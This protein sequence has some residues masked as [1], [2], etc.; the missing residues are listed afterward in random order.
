MKKRWNSKRIIAI[1]MAVAMLPLSDIANAF[2]PVVH[3]A[4]VANSETFPTTDEDMHQTTN[5][6]AAKGVTD[7]SAETAEYGIALSAELDEQGNVQLNWTLNGAA[8]EGVYT[9]YRNELA[10]ETVS[11]D[12]GQKLSYCDA[13]VIASATYSYC[14]EKNSEKSEE[15]LPEPGEAKDA[16]FW[17]NSVNVK[18]P[19]SLTIENDSV[20]IDEDMEVLELNMSGGNLTITPDHKLTVIKDTSLSDSYLYI[21]GQLCC[22]GNLDVKS[23]YLSMYSEDVGLYVGKD[24]TW[25]GGSGYFGN[26]SARFDGNCDLN[27]YLTSYEDSHIIFGG[28]SRQDI[29]IQ[30]EY[31]AIL[32]C[33]EFQNTSSEGIHL[34]NTF[35]CE[36]IIMGD[37]NVF[38]GETKVTGDISL[39][40]DTVYEGDLCLIGKLELNGHT[41]SVKGNLIQPMGQIVLGGGK[42]EV[43]GDYRMLYPSE[44]GQEDTVSYGYIEME[45]EQDE[46]IICGDLIVNRIDPIYLEQGRTEIKGDIILTSSEPN[47]EV[48]NF[49]HQVVLSGEGKQEIISENEAYATIAELLLTNSS[50]DGIVFHDNI[51]VTQEIEDQCGKTFGNLLLNGEVKGYFKGNV[52]VNDGLSVNDDLTIDGDLTINGGLDVGGSCVVAGNLTID[53]G[54]FGIF[55][56]GYL[57]IK[58]NFFYSSSYAY[59]S[60]DAGTIECK[61]NLIS[62]GRLTA[63]GDNRFLFS[64]NE[65]QIISTDINDR[66]AII[67]LKNTSAE[68]VQADRILVCSSLIKNDSKFE[69]TQVALERDKR[70]TEDQVYEGNLVWKEGLLDLNGRELHV[71]GNL[72][73]ESGMIDLNNGRLIIDGDYKIQKSI[74]EQGEESLTGSGLLKMDDENDYLLV[75][76]SFLVD[77]TAYGMDSSD[78]FTNGVVE[79]K[80]DVT[81]KSAGENQYFNPKGDSTLLLSGEKQQ[82]IHIEKSHYYYHSGVNHLIITNSSDAGVVL[83]DKIY[84]YGN[85]EDR[86]KHISGDLILTN[87]A[88]LTGKSFGGNLWIENYQDIRDYKI[89]GDLHLDCYSAKIYDCNVVGD[90]YSTANVNLDGTLNVD[91]NLRI[92]SGYI[93][94][95][96]GTIKVG[97]DLII[98]DNR[99]CL[100]MTHEKDCVIVAGNAELNP[101]AKYRMDE[102]DLLIAGSLSIAGDLTYGNYLKTSESHKLIL[103]GSSGQTVKPTSNQTTYLGTIIVNNQSAKGVVFDIA[104]EKYLQFKRLSNQNSKLVIAGK[105]FP[106]NITILKSSASFSHDEVIEG[107]VY[108]TGSVNVNLCKLVINGDLFMDSSIDVFGG[109]LEVKG[110]LIQSNGILEVRNS[111]NVTIDGDYRIQS[112]TVEGEKVSYSSSSGRLLMDSINETVL[113]KGNFISASTYCP[114]YYSDLS[115]GLLEVQ[116][117]FIIDDTYEK[118]TFIPYEEFT[119]K[120]SG[121]GK[122]IVDLGE[123]GTDNNYFWNLILANDSEEGIVFRQTPYV[124]GKV[125]DESKKIT[126]TIYAASINNITSESFC[127]SLRTSGR[128]EKPLSIKGDLILEETDSLVVYDKL[129]VD[130]DLFARG[131][132]SVYDNGELYVK[133]NISFQKDSSLYISTGKLVADGN[134]TMDGSGDQE[135][136]MAGYTGYMLVKGNT[137]LKLTNCYASYGTLEVLGDFT[138]IDGWKASSGE[139]KTVFSGD[140]KQKI[141]LEGDQYFANVEFKNL[142]DEGIE[143]HNVTVNRLVIQWGSKLTGEK[144]KGS[145]ETRTVLLEDRTIEGNYVLD[146]NL[147][148]NGHTLTVTGDLVHRYGDILIDGGQLVTGGDYLVKVTSDDLKFPGGTFYSLQMTGPDDKVIVNGD[149]VV[150]E[151]DKK[152]T[153]TFTNGTLEVKGDL[154]LDRSQGLL[155]WRVDYHSTLVLS[156]KNPQTVTSKVKTYLENIVINNTSEEGV[157]IQQNIILYGSFVSDQKPVRGTIGITSGNVTFDDNS[158][159]GSIDLDANVS[160]S[161]DLSIGGNLR[162]NGKALYVKECTLTVGGDLTCDSNG[163]LYIQG[164]AVVVEGNATIQG[165][166]EMAQA[167][168][169]MRVKGNMLAAPQTAVLSNGLI[170]VGGNFETKKAFHATDDHQTELDGDHKQTVTMQSGTYLRNLRLKNTSEDGIYFESLYLT[171][172]MDPGDSVYS[173]GEGAGV[174]GYT[175]TEDETYKGDL[176]LTGG[177]LDLNGH[178]LVVTGNLIQSS[179]TLRINAG[180]LRIGG[181]YKQTNESGILEMTDPSDSVIV[182]GNF[183]Y[184]YGKKIPKSLA[185][186]TLELKGNGVFGYYGENY[187]WDMSGLTLIFSGEQNQ[188]ITINKSAS[189]GN[190]INRNSAEL[191][192]SGGYEN[193]ITVSGTISDEIRSNRIFGSV[194]RVQSEDQIVDGIYGGNVGFSKSIQLTRDLKVRALTQTTSNVTVSMGDRKLEAEN[195]SV[196]TGALALQKGIITCNSFNIGYSGKLHMQDAE[197]RII[198]RGDFNSYA[199]EDGFLTAGTMEIYG[200]FVAY[201]K[202]AFVTSAEHTVVFPATSDPDAG[203]QSITV[204]DTT[205]TSK[206]TNLILERAAGDYIFSQ[207]LDAIAVNVRFEQRDVKAPESISN[208]EAVSITPTTIVIQFTESADENGIGGYRIER[209]GTIIATIKD[210]TYRD[211]GLTPDT[212]Y[213]YKVYPFDTSFNNCEESPV[214]TVKT[215]KDQSAPS[216]PRLSVKSRT[217]SSITLEWTKVFDDVKV[218]RYN[219]YR[220]EVKIAAGLTETTF[221]DTHLSLKTVYRYQVEAYDTSGNVSV[222]SSILDT[223]VMMPEFVSIEPAEESE[224]GGEKAILSV[225]FRIPSKESTTSLKIEY[226]TNTQE[227]TTLVTKF[228]TKETS[229]GNG[230]WQHVAS[231]SWNLTGLAGDQ[232]INVR[233]T[234]TD[235]DGNSVTE[236]R[237][238][239]LDR[240]APKPPTEIDAVAKD[241]TVILEWAPSVNADCA[242]YKIYRKHGETGA[243]FLIG[244]IQKASMVYYEDSDVIPG[245]Y[246]AYAIRAYDSFGNLG[247]LSEAAD[248]IVDNDTE[249]P[250]VTEI[251]PKAKRINGIVDLGIQATDNRRVK[252]ILLQYREESQQTWTELAQIN[253]QIPASYRL[254][255]TQ[256]PDG[257]Y[258]FGAVAVDSSGNKSEEKFTKRY[259]IDNTGIAKIEIKES[260]ALSTSI[261]ISWEDVEEEDFGYFLVEQLINGSYKEVARVKDRLG[262]IADGLRPLT[263]YT[264]RVAGVDTLGNKGEY[265]DPVIVSTEADTIAPVITQVLPY[266]GDVKNKLE[267]SLNAT[268]NVELGDAVISYSVDGENFVDL[269]TL[270]PSA[271]SKSNCYE[272]MFDIREMVE[273]DIYLKFE[274]YD[275]AGNHNALMQ[276]EDD[277]IFKYTIDR[278]PPSQINSITSKV[279]EGFT[280]LYW[281]I[282]EN[283]GIADFVISRA[284]AKN[285]IF[286][287]IEEH[288]TYLSYYDQN[289]QPGETYLYKIAAV[290]RAGNRGEFSPEFELKVEEDTQAPVITGILPA[291][292]TVLGL[293]AQIE[294][295][296]IDNIHTKKL[297]LEYRRIAE[298]ETEHEWKQIAQLSDQS[299]CEIYGRVTWKNGDIENG[300][301]QIRAIAEDAY[302]NISEPFVLNYRL[303]KAEPPVPELTVTGSHYRMELEYSVEDEQQ[304]E[305]YEILRRVVGATDFKSILYTDETSY[306]DTDV[307]ADKVYQYRVGAYFKNGSVSWSKVQEGVADAIDDTAPVA[308]LPENLVGL[309]GMEIAFDGMGSYDNVRVVSYEW[310][311]GDGTVLSG[312][313]PI[314]AFNAAGEY[315]VTL[316]VKDAAGNSDESSTEVTIREKSGNGSAILEV[317]GEKG[318]YIPYAYVHVKAEDGTEVNL[319]ADGFGRAVIAGAVGKCAVSAFATGYLPA[320]TEVLLFEH[321]PMNYQL[322]L[323]KEELIVG[324]LT[325][326]R[327]TIQE[328]KEAGVDL[329]DPSNYNQVQIS[330]EL[331]YR[332]CKN[333][334]PIQMIGPK[335]QTVET[336]DHTRITAQ[337][338]NYSYTPG[339][340]YITPPPVICIQTV[341]EISW[342]KDMFQ[343]ELDILNAADAEYY[344]KGT[345]A[346]LVLPEGVSLAKMNSVQQTLTQDLGTVYGQ[347]QSHAEWIVRGDTPGIKRLHADVNGILMPFE[348]PVDATFETEIQVIGG[349]GL[350]VYIYPEKHVV[351]GEDTYIQFAIVN[352]T[353]APV[354][355]FST[356]IGDYAETPTVEY[357]HDLDTGEISERE[358]SGIGVLNS[359]NMSQPVRIRDGQNLTIKTLQ[360]GG[361]VNGTLIRKVQSREAEDLQ[362][363]ELVKQAEKII[364]GE[365]T[366]IHLHTE[367][368]PGHVYIYR[369]SYEWQRIEEERIRREEEEAYRE[370]QKRIQQEEERIR[371]EEEARLQEEAEEVGDPI[372]LNTGHFTDEVSLLSVAGA[373]LLDISMRYNSG[374]S[375]FRGELGFGWHHDYEKRLELVNGTIYYHSTPFDTFTFLKDEKKQD[376]MVGRMEGSTLILAEGEEYTYGHYKPVSRAMTGTEMVRNTDG[377]YTLTYPDLRQYQFTADG[378]LSKVDDGTGITISFTYYENETVVTDDLS[379]KRLHIGYDKYHRIEKVWDD[380]G[381]ETR[382]TYE[383]D[384]LSSVTNPEGYVTKYTYDADH[385]ILTEANQQ[386]VYVDNHYD[387]HGRVTRQLNPEGEAMTLSYENDGGKTLITTTYP[388]SIVKKTL[389]NASGSIEWMLDSNGAKTEYFYDAQGNRIVEQDALGHQIAKEYD[390]RGN[391]TKIT[392]EAGNIS[393][394]EYDSHDRLLSATNADGIRS[395]FWYDDYGRPVRTADTEGNVVT[396]DYNEHGQLIKQCHEILGE[397]TFTYE[398]GL[399]KESTDYMGN[400]TQ[401]EYDGAGNLTKTTDALGNTT[402]NTYDKLGRVV[403]AT[404]ALGGKTRYTYDCNNRITS[405]TNALGDTAS[406][407]YDRVGHPVKVTYPDGSFEEQSYDACG[408]L[409]SIT[410][411]D[412]SKTVYEY[413][414]VGNRVKEIWPDGRTYTAEYDL[415]G[416]RIAEKDTK[417]NA[418]CYEY[419]PNGNLYKVKHQDGTTELYTYNKQ[420]KVAAYT[421]VTGATTSYSYDLMNRLTLERDAL[422]NETHY[423]YDELGR[424]ISQTDPN[425]NTTK[426]E[427]DANSNCTKIIDALG[428]ATYMEY[429]A[430][431]R[432]TCLYRLNKAGEKISVSYIYDAL[433]HV[434]SSTDELGQTTKMTYDAAGNLVSLVDPDGNT[435]SVSEYDSMGRAVKV[436]DEKLLETTCEYDKSGNLIE[437]V[438]FLNGEAKRSTQYE[439]DVNN[440]LV[441]VTDPMDG[442]TKMGYDERGNVASITDPN[443]GETVYTYDNMGRLLSEVDAIGSKH[444]YT[445]NAQ[446]LLTQQKNARGQETEYT[447]DKIGRVT[448]IKDDL[449]T[450]NYTYDKNGNVLTVSD[451]KGTIKRTYDALNRITSYTDYNGKT[452]KYAYDEL[453]NLVGL[454]Y[455]GGEIVRYA[456]YK[457]GMLYSVTDPEGKITTYE[458][459]SRGNLTKTVRPNGTV[460][461]CT[462]NI[463][464]LLVEQIETLNAAEEGGEATELLHY[465]YT[466]DDYGNVKA[467]DGAKTLNTPEGISRLTSVSMT[468][469]AA[470][471]LLTYNGEVVRYDADG[472]MIYGPVNGEMSSLTYDCRNRLVSAGGITYTYDPENTRISAESDTSKEVYVTENV[473]GTYSR[474]LTMTV[475]EKENGTVKGEGKETFYVYGSGLIYEK[476][477]DSILYH[478]YNN[479]GS[480]ILLTDGHGQTIAEYTYG[481]YGE[482]LSGDASLTRFLYNGRCGVSTD[483][484]G[485]YYMRQRYYN[486]EIRRFI[487]RDIVSGDITNSQSLNR[488]CYVQ[489]NPVKYTDPF[490]LSPEDG[491][492][493]GNNF[494]HGLLGLV[495]LIP[496]P[497]GIAA[498]V[499]DGAIYLTEGNYAMAAMSFADAIIPAAGLVG[500]A[501]MNT[502]KYARIGATIATGAKVASST[503]N[504]ARGMYIADKAVTSF[505]ERHKDDLFTKDFHWTR[506]D[507]LDALSFGMASVTCISSGTSLLHNLENF[508]AACNDLSTLGASVGCFVAGTV[509]KTEDGDKNIEEIEVGDKVLAYEATTGTFAYKE[510]VDFIAHDGVTELAHVTITPQ[511]ELSVDGDQGATAGTESD[512]SESETID[513][514]TNHPYFVVGYGYVD[515]GNLRTG[516]TILLANGEKGTVNSVD[517]EFLEEP[518]T[519]YNFEVKEWHCYFVGEAGVLVHNMKKGGCGVAAEAAGSAAGNAAGKTGGNSGKGGSKSVHGNS[520]IS[521]K[522]QHGYEIYNKKTGDV[523]KTGISG[524]PLNKNGTSPRANT[525]VNKL[526]KLA[527]EDIYDARI[528]IEDMPDRVSALE[529]EKENALKLWEEGNSMAIHKRPRPWED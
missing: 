360:P 302:G 280:G 256:I 361:V 500:K 390:S 341:K 415:L 34:L 135:F 84:A 197:G 296:A 526:N 478:H 351:Q 178:E 30:S 392:D 247:E 240:Q 323:Q 430:L 444:S 21:N 42:L 292:D 364:K 269:V 185:C 259:E 49:G 429:D 338:I 362:Y 380:N 456:Y 174:L 405:V 498:N 378:R 387:D 1:I 385:Y 211:T 192:L 501:M 357:V 85:V 453:G 7:D 514:T 475:Y 411:A 222:K 163:E 114:G 298:D 265:S 212:E 506:A 206:F 244:E 518:V 363:F 241:G 91:G 310:N 234:L 16:R 301:Y 348:A 243:F 194:V 148:L 381:R 528:V 481:A 155:P 12:A 490:G 347:Q 416:N 80:G 78:Q 142:S 455:P 438:M 321:Q 431:N 227:W 295:L 334:I 402:L 130:G 303:D 273:G 255:T 281:E 445:Y 399:L 499:I 154:T 70:L 461:I 373:S 440:R 369:V 229:L 109:N 470:N 158:F 136:R 108:L 251:T 315:T 517:I 101:R 6:E 214:L 322:V 472:N 492:A 428:D 326:Q 129:T 376:C 110:D 79:V 68:G 449:G 77:T 28:D 201:G 73:H 52:L 128:L 88:K 257:T 452:V 32:P 147:D 443:G 482:L 76:G 388:G 356:T 260:K 466:Y 458:Y 412:G 279:E 344:I 106:K 427:Y 232:D 476:T 111:G 233:F 217:G 497:I 329:S 219:L 426:Y 205:G 56:D 152:F 406:Y 169:V 132:L 95:Q 263:S 335:P 235:A 480:T 320:D 180:T 313:Q 414:S 469:D 96:E 213:T 196:S 328:M 471:R 489:G 467:V 124:C 515:A 117:D 448:S 253:Y 59:N 103:N 153:W 486:V 231:Y 62:K 404:D 267:I 487:N 134:F 379:G 118:K 53:E 393:C 359:A 11:I 36:K 421:D 349:T 271:S 182:G 403:E 342:L 141:V 400:R 477:G 14:I 451:G 44:D 39:T 297:T 146:E 491:K 479:L 358:V 144:L 442:V 189:I 508:E 318:E 63:T 314:H 100:K 82:K 276:D 27:G 395:S 371:A 374:S 195:V 523:V 71:T 286:S 465:H 396:Y 184:E 203:K 58:K 191:T 5:Q 93:D 86:S 145:Y 317:L 137:Y 488:Y 504:L 225:H 193:S 512:A 305:G 468:Y 215:T 353:N 529:W 496:G 394:M 45:Q 439:Y 245:D 230:I 419:Y 157:C 505:C 366:G 22:Q 168:S 327:M 290:D 17:S 312:P 307:D 50:N 239:H 270:K 166:Y 408:N 308:V 397:T 237:T 175:L 224:I 123:E 204:T 420:W 422:G 299:R 433:G 417:G 92:D 115:G 97:G 509:V 4:E 282:P 352:A 291:E 112:K 435:V 164:G 325:A 333:P 485:L 268:D 332:G 209:N 64:G 29:C 72:I 133:G 368:V 350:H 398:N 107:D 74:P 8:Q 407:T 207:S 127:G 441:K 516:D 67:E 277:V 309:V 43:K 19:N 367:V 238:Y 410:Y 300:D 346:N 304:V 340:A 138:A 262:Y 23:S 226:Q 131:N 425:G 220:N 20:T 54:Y 161:N 81:V 9:I 60:I 172:S 188:R 160:L 343:V 527:G 495:G 65:K 520:K 38:I 424:M 365:E 521:T 190:L 113:V 294:V 119:V 181:D 179:G 283:E 105:E 200:N 37:S 450:V 432:M 162:T 13:D 463:S 375:A 48:L 46:L 522:P 502:C 171:G 41:L 370:E 250:R 278:T 210:T 337:T 437:T 436:T 140:K 409:A 503:F 483:A 2:P 221:Q 289:I 316:K 104:D 173:M 288:Y 511:D 484:N 18:I 274:V 510:V 15:E 87:N 26:A 457:N 447:Y 40:E 116:G 69:Y 75:G 35:P 151:T 446:G 199:T 462:Y 261:S 24:T 464:G 208:L 330:V 454:T 94:M 198:V 186:G 287:V 89:G 319:R 525:Q 33:I 459:D 246:Y 311:M 159:P 102:Q 121:A 143:L 519:V 25:Q 139:F 258:L 275:K 165:K 339:I 177:L 10:L 524:Q 266:S 242:G 98:S 384:D 83:V 125:T 377:T 382:L 218:A 176:L 249:A 434:V 494:W 418:V 252:Y 383:N 183:D 474:V 423:S 149:F 372:D 386:G 228:G 156:G 254:D 120:L 167:E 47:T 236:I 51:K 324:R 223:A 55:E 31:Y 90:F 272:Y 3:A 99:G 187:G 306:T 331:T 150:G 284:N 354:Y 401:Y 57:L 391:V 413:D 345:V 170:V 460:E 264:F 513:S 473:S 61:G 493:K 66:F 507:T 285:R 336:P 202:K 355:G 122:Q 126:G 389:L 293:N 248:V 216:V